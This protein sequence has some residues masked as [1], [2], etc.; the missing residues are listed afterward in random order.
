[1]VLHL[2]SGPRNISTALMYSFAQRP[3]TKV[4]DEPFYAVY[5]KISGL[6][7][8]GREQ[9]LRALDQDPHKVFEF[10]NQQEQ[11][12]GNVFVKNMGHHL[13][14]FNYE[15]IK[16]YQNIFLIREP[17][18]M[19]YSY[20]KVREQPTL[21]D[22]GIKQQADLF[23]WLQAEGQS[24]VVLDGSELLRNPAKVLTELCTRLHLPFTQS[25]LS[26]PAGPRPEDGCWAPYW[27]ANVHQSTGFRPPD[28][29]S[30]TLPENL[31]AVKEASLPY[32]NYL[33]KY[34]I[35]A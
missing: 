28:S 34:A 2:I 9:V 35:L 22:I 32:Y 29:V 15:Q 23:T 33:K 25:M 10:I 11:E 8:P 26:W 18:Q 16:N 7:H 3:D 5:L 27:Y 14:G 21:N 20:A 1:M 13:Q 30:T 31:A 4:M 6:H 12:L 19:L 17:G 24:P